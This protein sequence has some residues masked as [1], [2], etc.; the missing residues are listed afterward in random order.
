MNVVAK[1]GSA[2]L[3]SPLSAAATSVGAS[4]AVCEVRHNLPGPLKWWQEKVGLLPTSIG[5]VALVRVIDD[6]WTAVNVAL[7]S[8]AVGSLFYN[9]FGGLCN[10]YESAR[11]FMEGVSD[12]LNNVEA[13]SLKD[14]EDAFVDEFNFLTGANETIETKFDLVKDAYGDEN[15]ADAET[16]PLTTFFMSAIGARRT[17]KKTPTFRRS[18]DMVEDTPDVDS[19]E[20]ESLMVEY[21]TV[22]AHK[23]AFDTPMV[24]TYDPTPETVDYVSAKADKIPW[25][26]C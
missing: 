3:L 20:Y 5:V 10:P 26:C 19:K 22:E 6:G 11:G 25:V 7:S 9:P 16:N 21:N 18:S 24:E 4:A 23:G 15:P 14:V 8:L 2:L 17:K 12:A 13:P 1:A